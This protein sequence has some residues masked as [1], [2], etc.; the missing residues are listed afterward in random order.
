MLIFLNT[1]N[2]G[3]ISTVPKA[4]SEFVNEGSRYHPVSR[5]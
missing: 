4:K 5:G 1:L 2:L 3:L